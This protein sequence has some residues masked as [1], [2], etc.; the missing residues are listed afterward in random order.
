MLRELST[1]QSRYP[2]WGWVC[3]STD[4][5]CKRIVELDAARQNSHFCLTSVW[6]LVLVRRYPSSF[7]SFYVV[8]RVQTFDMQIFGMRNV[9]DCYGKMEHE[10]Q[11]KLKGAES[12]SELIRTWSA[13]LV[14]VPCKPIYVQ[15][16]VA[17]SKNGCRLFHSRCRL[18]GSRMSCLILLVVFFFSFLFFFTLNEY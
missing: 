12:A 10:C 4:L 3:I 15:D 18:L 9:H 11:I 8:R 7:T 16:F 5:I 1:F 13:L 17:P 2:C 14:R 6:V